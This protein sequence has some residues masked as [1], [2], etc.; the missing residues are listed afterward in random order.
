MST[1]QELIEILAGFEKDEMSISEL[2]ARVLA[3]IRASPKQYLA[4]D[5]VRALRDFFAWYLD[6]YD[7]A[8]QPRSGF[9]G[10][11]KDL[12]DQVLRGEYRISEAALKN[13]GNELIDL[14][15]RAGGHMNF[16]R[17]P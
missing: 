4:E 5:E 14:L 10:R 3:I 16:T 2:R 17:Q 1:R 11:M 7:P 8:L 15:Q 12:L 6:K 9:L 13:K